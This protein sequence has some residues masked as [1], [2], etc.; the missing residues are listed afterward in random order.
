MDR[1]A[2]Q[3]IVHGGCKESDMTEETECLHMH[4]LGIPQS[5]L[6][7]EMHLRNP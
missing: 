1:G 5:L 2:W 3:T 6:S 4:K 7:L